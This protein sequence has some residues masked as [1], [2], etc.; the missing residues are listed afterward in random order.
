MVITGLIL[1]KS[2]HLHGLENSFSI[3]WIVTGIGLTSLILI[4]A[5]MLT[6]AMLYLVQGMIS[7]KEARQGENIASGISLDY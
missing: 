1:Q 3:L 6:W 7:F 2:R 4:P 5:A